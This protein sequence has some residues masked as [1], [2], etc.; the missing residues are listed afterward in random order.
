MFIIDENNGIIEEFKAF[1][2]LYWEFLVV[3]MGNGNILEESIKKDKNLLKNMNKSDKNLISIDD[4]T[5]KWRFL[6][7]E[8][9]FNVLNMYENIKMVLNSKL[10][11]LTCSIDN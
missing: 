8:H 10:F 11:P 7:L 2:K 6:R 9:K 5:L 4:K 1:V 3:W